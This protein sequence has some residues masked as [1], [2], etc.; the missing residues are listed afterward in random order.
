MAELC[1]KFRIK[2]AKGV[3][4]M[5][6]VDEFRSSTQATECQKKVERRL[7]KIKQCFVPAIILTVLSVL[8]MKFS[9]ADNK[10]LETLS[11]VV[12][13]VNMILLTYAEAWFYVG[14]LLVLPFRKLGTI[15]GFLVFIFYFAPCFM[16]VICAPIVPLLYEK[17]L[18]GITMECCKDII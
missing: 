2:K 12:V 10:L 16:A 9:T 18:C 4:K 3:R 5:L 7:N 13:V 15:I 1:D 6:G 17:Y 8:L 11:M 14:K